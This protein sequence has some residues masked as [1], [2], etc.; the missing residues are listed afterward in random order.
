LGIKPADN[1]GNWILRLLANSSDRGKVRGITLEKIRER[2]ELFPIY[3]EC[4]RLRNELHAKRIPVPLTGE[5]ANID[6]FPSDVAGDHV[7]N[8]A[9]PSYGTDLRKALVALQAA[10]QPTPKPTGP[11]M[12][13]A[14]PATVT[15]APPSD[16][17]PAEGTPLRKVYDAAETAAGIKLFPAQQIA[18]ERAFENSKAGKNSAMMMPTS[19]GKTY[20]IIAYAE[21][22][23]TQMAEDIAARLAAPGG[24]GLAKPQLHITTTNDL[25]AEEGAKNA[26]RI[27][28][29]FSR[30]IAYLGKK[31][32]RDRRSYTKTEDGGPRL[33]KRR[34]MRRPTSYTACLN[35]STSSR[36]RTGKN[37]SRETNTWGRA[38][39]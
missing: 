5:V 21:M 27:L 8:K 32:R 35:I 31:N 37:F 34:P 33:M 10:A 9:D 28:G 26:A 29:K 1:A 23:L 17:I 20:T 16:S 14:G 13:A 18:A 30:K 2:N 38:E 22:L 11:H 39:R 7:V 25:L 24:A 19:A 15:L 6:L 12:T 3:N 4:V 36:R